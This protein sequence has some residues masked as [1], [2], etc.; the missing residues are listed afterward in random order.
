MSCPVS[1]AREKREGVINQELVK[2]IQGTGLSGS[3]QTDQP[4]EW[5]FSEISLISRLYGIQLAQVARALRG[6]SFQWSIRPISVAKH[7][8]HRC[9]SQKHM[10][11]HRHIK[12]KPWQDLLGANHCKFRISRKNGIWRAIQRRIPAHISLLIHWKW[13]S[14]SSKL[15]ELSCGTSVFLGNREIHL[16]LC[17]YQV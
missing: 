4:P 1:T 3:L 11:W 17:E 9:Y 10:C 5:T 13:D 12:T 7:A 2:R 16:L 6:R 14:H 15:R 8:I